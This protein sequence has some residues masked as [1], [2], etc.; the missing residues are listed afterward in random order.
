MSDT[1]E[2][3][4]VWHD[5]SSLGVKGLAWADEP[6]E[7][8]FDRYPEALKESLHEELWRLCTESAGLFVDF[9]SAAREIHVRWTMEPQ[10]LG[11]DLRFMT[12]VAHSGMDLYGKDAKGQWRWAGA[13]PAESSPEGAAG[14]AG[15][16]PLNRVPLDGK[17]RTYRIY[18]PLLRRMKTCEIGCSQELEPCATETAAVDT[19]APETTAVDTMRPLAYYGTSIVHGIAV[20]RPGMTH[21]AQLG[22]LL[23]REVFNLGVSG[24][25]KCEPE[26]A[27]ALTRL[28]VDLYIFDVLPNN[29][30]AELRERLPRFLRI[31]R[32][33]DETTPILL[34]GDRTF[35]DAT[36]CP[37]RDTVKATKD[38][39]LA[40]VVDELR[41]AGMERLHTAL[42]PDWFGEDREGTVDSSHPNSLGSYRFTRRLLPLV[43]ERLRSGGP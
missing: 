32:S 43:E 30:D 38:R 22:R 28:D 18:M 41:E 19:T 12:P 36:F 17:L 29:S 24:Q 13:C 23:N 35:G 39:A 37:E 20:D 25:A 5:V 8:P 34:I 9:Q 40:D 33:V 6:R 27:K 7:G 10:R 21:A 26:I 16:G 42:D 31:V 14:D 15:N 3:R 2:Q 11:R 1:S 4:L